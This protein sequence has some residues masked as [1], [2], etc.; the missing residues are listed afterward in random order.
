MAVA[1][2][3]QGEMSSALDDASR[4]LSI[5]D[6]CIGGPVWLPRGVRSSIARIRRVLLAPAG[7]G[8]TAVPRAARPPL[9]MVSA[10]RAE[11]AFFLGDIGAM[12]SSYASMMAFAAEPRLRARARARAYL[13]LG[14]MAALLGLKG[15]AHAAWDSARE[16]GEGLGDNVAA[17]HGHLGE[18]IWHM[19][20]GRWQEARAQLQSAVVLYANVA[21]P[22]Y[23]KFVETLLAL[24][25]HFRGDWKL[26]LARFAALYG[27]GEKQRNRST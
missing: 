6:D 14:H 25:A 8:N 19:S 18:A 26:S 10:I 12:E 16:L 23:P 27:L 17:S 11:M 22:A 1:H 15:T 4:A 5:L 21:D 20:F 24:E 13:F 2:W 3:A 7:L 9:V